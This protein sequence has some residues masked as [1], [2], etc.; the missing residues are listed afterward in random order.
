V[1]EVALNDVVATDRTTLKLFPYDKKDAAVK[2]DTAELESGLLK[3]LIRDNSLS[4]K[5]TL[6]TGPHAK[7]PANAPA[8]VST[9]GTTVVKSTSETFTPG[10]S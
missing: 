5:I 10:E 3:T 1:F 9:E 4:I 2:K 8:V 7:V 6:S